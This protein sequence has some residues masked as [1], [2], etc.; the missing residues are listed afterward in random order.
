MNKLVSVITPTYNCG[1]YI[2]D[3]IKSV[4]DQTYTNWEMIIVDDKSTDNTEELVKKY[5]E[6]DSRI[7]YYRLERNS[8]AAVARTKAME[9]AKGNYMAFLDSDDL[10]TS[11]KLERQLKFMERN[12]I[13]FSCTS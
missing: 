3:T 1:D 6:S 9:M 12:K 7:K 13:N 5:A 2:E 10:W 4:I 11:N 8:G